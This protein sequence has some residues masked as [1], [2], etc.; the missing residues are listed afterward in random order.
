MYFVLLTIASW[1]TL[2]S[3]S[4][5]GLIW[6]SY[7]FAPTTGDQLNVMSRS[8]V[9]TSSAGASSAGTVDQV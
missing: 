1:M 6:I 3:Q 8:G 9:P 5:F 7:V 4:P 2:L